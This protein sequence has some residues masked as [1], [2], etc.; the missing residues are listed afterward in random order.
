LLQTTPKYVQA[1]LPA[2]YSLLWHEQPRRT[3]QL[4][5]CGV[6]FVDWND[7]WIDEGTADLYTNLNN[8]EHKR[9][10]AMQTKIANDDNVREEMWAMC[11]QADA[12]REA[13]QYIEAE[14]LYWQALAHPA[15]EDEVEWA[16]TANSLGILYKYMGRYDEA[17]PLYQKSLAIL[18]RNIG[19]D[20][21]DIASLYHNLGGLEHARGNYAKGE[22][23]ARRSVEIR[24]A[25]L[26]PD[27]P[28]VAADVAALAAL[29]DG[30]KR[31]EEAEPLY[32][33][34]LA[35]FEHEFG[36]EDMEIAIN[37]NN[38]AAIRYQ[39]EAYEAA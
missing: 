19:P 36:P 18:E 25:A 35:I 24:E 5:D 39:Q 34:A 4:L 23:F 15:S 22:P 3:P 20:H 32:Q 21:H 26:G 10:A 13:G 11:E 16:T 37:L 9:E 2:R 12:Y 7:F 38:L 28:H 29:I 8:L 6:L 17:E 33:R 14:K 31:F 1:F 30:Q 27:H